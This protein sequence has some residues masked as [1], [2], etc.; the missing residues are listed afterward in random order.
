LEKGLPNLLRAQFYLNY[1]VEI[2]TSFSSWL[3]SFFFQMG[4]TIKEDSRVGW[5][6][7]NQW[8]RCLLTS[9]TSHSKRQSNWWSVPATPGTLQENCCASSASSKGGFTSG[10]VWHHFRCVYWKCL[11]EDQESAA[12]GQLPRKGSIN[13]S[14]GSRCTM[15]NSTLMTS[16]YRESYHISD[17]CFVGCRV[18]H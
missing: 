13:V 1:F 4:W 18:M 17:W 2:S 9:G 3:G 10:S 5:N 11:H 12:P 7:R 14:R 8:S 16:C 15:G 6:T